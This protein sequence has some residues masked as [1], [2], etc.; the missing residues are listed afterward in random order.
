[1][2]C[3]RLITVFVTMHKCIKNSA[4]R[5]VHIM[6]YNNIDDDMV[7]NSWH[8]LHRAMDQHTE[9]VPTTQTI[10]CVYLHVAIVDKMKS[11]WPVLSEKRQQ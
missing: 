11:M 8:P 6:Q 7:W 9:V 5:I 2:G 10:W 1:M 4:Q 3:T